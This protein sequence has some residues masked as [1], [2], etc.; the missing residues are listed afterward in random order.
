MNPLRGY[1]RRCATIVSSSG[2]SLRCASMN[3][4]SSGVMSSFR[5]IGWY[6][7]MAAKWRI[8]ARTSVAIQVQALRNQV[9]I[10]I[11]IARRIA[12]QQRGERRIV[13]DDDA[14]FA[15]QNLAA[16]R[17]NRHIANAVLLRRGG[18]VAALHHLQLPQPVSQHQKD[19][20]DYV[21]R[22]RQAD[23]RYFVVAAE[24]K[25]VPSTRY[26]VFP[27]ESLSL[28]YARV[29]VVGLFYCNAL[30]PCMLA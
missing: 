30:E 1:R 7:G 25:S 29:V 5:K 22:R 23:F 10:R 20:Q 17:E 11:E 18:V 8:R 14:P 9:R 24:H 12:Q 28:R 3:A 16:G 2:S 4:S 6:C 26:P 21:L 27:M 15:V 13:V 19:G